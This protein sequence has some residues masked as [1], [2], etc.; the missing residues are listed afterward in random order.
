MDL[1]PQVLIVANTPARAEHL[2][3]WLIP[4]G[5]Q[6]RVAMTFASAMI[7]LRTHPDLVITELKLGPYNGLHVAFRARCEG[8]PAVAIGNPDTVL[9]R[10]ARQLGA[11]FV[12]SGELE[13]DR[14]LAVVQAL[15]SS[16][17]GVAEGSR[18]LASVPILPRGEEKQQV[19]VPGGWAALLPDPGSSHYK[20]H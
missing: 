5:Y 17:T 12:K 1:R 6:P 14:L 16:R 4:R 13:R 9:E 11:T 7:Q 19:D 18:P 3:G 20:F 8:I 10:D 2:R 15:I